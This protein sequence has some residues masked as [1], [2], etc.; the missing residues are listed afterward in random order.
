MVF[1][2]VLDEKM[3][4]QM[5]QEMIR[6][7]KKSSLMSWYD[8]FVDD[9]WNRDVHGVPKAEIK[10]LFPDCHIGL[11]R[12]FGFTAGEDACI[13]VVDGMLSSQPPSIS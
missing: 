7:V 8:F 6:V 9:P 2:S 10:R 13:L 5:P 11:E 4:Q 12:V 1:T 3:R